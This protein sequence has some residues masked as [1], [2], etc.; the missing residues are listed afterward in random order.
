MVSYMRSLPN[1]RPPASTRSTAGACMDTRSILYFAV[2]TIKGKRLMPA[3]A[4]AA[5]LLFVVSAPMLLADADAASRDL[6]RSR[7]EVAQGGDMSMDDFSDKPRRKQAGWI[8]HRASRVP[9]ARQLAEAAEKEDAGQWPEACKAYDRLVRSFPFAA[10]SSVAQLRLARLMEKRG[11]YKRAYEE[12]LYTLQFYPENAPAD[13]ILRQMYAIAN[14][15]RGEGKESRA[16]DYFKRLAEAAPHWKHTPQVLM[17]VGDAHFSRRDYYE[18]ADAYDTIT[19]TFPGTPVALEALAKHAQTL[20]A[21]S[22]KYPRDD[23]IQIHAIA[24]TTAALRDCPAELPSRPKLVANLDDLNKR[25]VETFFQMALFYDRDPAP[26]E[27][28]IAA[29]KDFLRRFPVSHRTAQAQSR[30]DALERESKRAG[31]GADSR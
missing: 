26:A 25:R 10:A 20:Y 28:R 8:F 11:K 1:G 30:L 6:A 17:Q 19:S 9:A 21:L 29:Y 4:M 22:L 12:Y 13:S 2:M 5:T 14:Y 24:I 15:Y 3:A 27:T 7:A 16:L 23:A 31:S 18:A